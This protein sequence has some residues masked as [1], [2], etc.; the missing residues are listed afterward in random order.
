MIWWKKLL[1]HAGIMTV[2]A[3]LALPF[4][5]YSKN[6]LETAVSDQVSALRHGDIAAA[7]A[8]TSSE[9]RYV[10]S[11]E[12]FT[13][14]VEHYKSLG[15]NASIKFT[16]SLDKG[17]DTGVVD[18]IV[19]SKE[20]EAT[21]INYLLVKEAKEWKILGMEIV[22]TEV[23]EEENS[24][25]ADIAS[26]FTVTKEYDN[27]LSKYKLKYPSSWI[28]ELPSKGTIIFSGKRGTKGYF[29]TVSIQTV[30]SK[31]DGGD[32]ATVKDFMA[33]IKKQ[34]NKLSPDTRLLDKGQFVVKDKNGSS[35]SGEYM[36]FTYKYKGEIFKQWQVVVLRK[37]KSVFYAWAYT[38]PAPLYDQYL[39]T[40][41]DILESWLIY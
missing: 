26:A 6:G 38:A 25:V 31:S 13:S 1:M 8:C 20:G 3:L 9:F 35:N 11:L 4:V 21:S 27:S 7:Y 15:D 39:K 32:F 28:Y 12:E 10:T 16:S 18:A 17:D 29:V 19:R 41:K 2:M 5:F 23:A 40:A 30:L 33:D 14:F 37:D 22:P 36:V 24:T 34:S